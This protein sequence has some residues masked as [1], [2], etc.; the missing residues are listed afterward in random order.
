M[1]AA[2]EEALKK[3][4]KLRES[5]GARIWK[6]FWKL[7]RDNETYLLQLPRTLEPRIQVVGTRKDGSYRQRF[8]IDKYDEK[9]KRKPES[10]YFTDKSSKLA[11]YTKA[12]RRLQEINRDVMPIL[13]F[14]D[15]VAV[16]TK[17]A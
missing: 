10:F 13:R 5:N 6:C 17:V 2:K 14:I 11:A 16:G 15:R 1:E 9:G 3:A 4:V 7:V 8:V 12:K